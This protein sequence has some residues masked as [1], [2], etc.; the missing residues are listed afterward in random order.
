MHYVTYTSFS[1]SNL[2]VASVMSFV[3]TQRF[4]SL[5]I[6]LPEQAAAAD[7]N[8]LFGR[9]MAELAAIDTRIRLVDVEDVTSGRPDPDLDQLVAEAAAVAL[10]PGHLYADT[11][12]AVLFPWFG[13]PVV[14]FDVDMLFMRDT[15]EA[16]VVPAGVT[17]AAAPDEIGTFG[18]A[19]GAA[20]HR[21]F[22]E[23]CEPD[24]RA[25]LAGRPALNI[26]LM[27]LAG[28]VRGAYARG[29]RTALRFLTTEPDPIASFSMGQLAW[30]HAMAHVPTTILDQSYNAASAGLR[31]L[32]VHPDNPPH[33]PRVR[34]Y[35]GI[36]EKKRMTLD[37]ALGM[38]RGFFRTP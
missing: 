17:C 13:H 18:D 21:R 30:N 16:F 6:L 19:R 11:L 35:I 22:T 27:V 14:W 20:V 7:G 38:S 31:E 12:R 1:H 2:A 28:D 34:H 29:L 25:A 33:Q 10:S 3:A 32:P 15:S 23:S 8:L 9:M 37:F 24:E 36:D 5:T 26:G 4:T